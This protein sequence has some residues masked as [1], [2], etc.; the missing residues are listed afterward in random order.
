MGSNICWN[1]INK[2]KHIFWTLFTMKQDIM[3]TKKKNKQFKNK[4]GLDLI[5]RFRICIQFVFNS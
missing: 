4:I 1:K 2:V 3:L 5:N